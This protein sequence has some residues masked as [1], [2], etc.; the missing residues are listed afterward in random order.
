MGTLLLAIR[1]ISCRASSAQVLLRD[2]RAMASTKWSQA[3]TV[4]GVMV[5]GMYL[6]LALRSMVRLARGSG[7]YLGLL[8]SRATGRR[9]NI[10]LDS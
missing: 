8:E 3:V 2:I 10:V 4:H 7:E 5:G 1:K 6:A 9:W